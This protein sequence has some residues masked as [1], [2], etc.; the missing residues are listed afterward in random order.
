MGG[1][2][3]E[4]APEE[5]RKMAVRGWKGQHK[6]ASGKEVRGWARVLSRCIISVL[7]FRINRATAV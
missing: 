2:R 7:S 6:I 5:G 1:R 3:N 4:Q